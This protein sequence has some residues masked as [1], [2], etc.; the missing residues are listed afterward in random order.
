MKTQKGIILGVVA[1]LT[2]TFYIG[3]NAFEAQAAIAQ[4][5]DQHQF[6]FAQALVNTLDSAQYENGD[7]IVYTGEAP[8][9]FTINGWTQV[10]LV[11]KNMIR[12]QAA[13]AGYEEIP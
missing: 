10:K 11:D 5:S 12:T 7:I 9:P 13:L 8:T 6:K 3:Y 4:S 1:I 2:V